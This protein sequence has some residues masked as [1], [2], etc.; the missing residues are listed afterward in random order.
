MAPEV[1]SGYYHAESDLWSLG[2]LLYSLVS[3]FVPF[4]GKDD[5]EIFNKIRGAKYNFDHKEFENVSDEC[6]DLIKKLLE[7]H[8][9]KRLTG[10]Q[11]LDH[12]WF[13]SQLRDEPGS[14]T[15]FMPKQKISD[16]VISR[17]RDF[18]GVS[19]FKR[20]V[21]DALVKTASEDDVLDLRK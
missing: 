16:E 7:V 6:K 15:H 21:M 8:P 1:V 12:P 3:G 11:A 2:V 14:P 20:A 4:D 10:K 17:L 5:N 18:K 9:K 19:Q 13:I